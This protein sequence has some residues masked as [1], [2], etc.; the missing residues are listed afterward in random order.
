MGRVIYLDLEALYSS[1][2]FINYGQK[3]YLI[4]EHICFTPIQNLERFATKRVKR[5]FD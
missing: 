5:F 4:L 2:T 3:R 1:W